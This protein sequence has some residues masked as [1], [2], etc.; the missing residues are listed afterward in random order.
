[1]WGTKVCLISLPTDKAGKRGKE[2]GQEAELSLEWAGCQGLPALPFRGLSWLLQLLS[3]SLRWRKARPVHI[4]KR[5]RP[6]RKLLIAAGL[7]SGV[8]CPTPREWVI[9]AWAGDTPHLPA[10]L[11]CVSFKLWALLE[12]C[13]VRPAVQHPNQDLRAEV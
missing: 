8:T 2:Q 1:M 7:K 9:W 13:P 3:P 6:S 10:G 4:P 12:A 11:V 5:L